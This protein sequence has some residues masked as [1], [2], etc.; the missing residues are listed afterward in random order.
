MGKC[1]AQF[2]EKNLPGNAGLTH[3]GGISKKLGLA[4]IIAFAID[5]KRGPQCSLTHR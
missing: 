2:I 3:L 4:V 5:I 1:Y